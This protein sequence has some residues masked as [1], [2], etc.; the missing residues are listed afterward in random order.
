MPY[1]SA[2]FIRNMPLDTTEVDVLELTRPFGKLLSV[3]F[4]DLDD[5]MRHC[6]VE[7]VFE[8]EEQASSLKRAF[9][10][11]EYAGAVL[12]INAVDAK[13]TEAPVWKMQQ[14]KHWVAAVDPI[15]EEE[16]YN[17]CAV[18]GT[19]IAVR[20]RASTVYIK[21]LR[22]ESAE[23]AIK[24]LQFRSP[25]ALEFATEIA[26][27]E[28]DVVHVAFQ[29]PDSTGQQ[30][31]AVVIDPL[32]DSLDQGA[33]EA[34]LAECRDYEIVVC[35]SAVQGP[36]AQ[37]AIIYTRSKR[38]MVPVYGTLHNQR[39][40]G[41]LL[42][43]FRYQSKEIP[44]R[45][46]HR[47]FEEENRPP[48]KMAIVV[49]PIAPTLSIERISAILVDCGKYDLRITRS[50]AQH[51]QNRL[52]VQPRNLQ[53]KSLCFKALHHRVI[54]GAELVCVRVKQEELPPALKR[55]DDDDTE[56]DG[57]DD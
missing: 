53:A 44:R 36:N 2:A 33:L 9:H 8:T 39:F 11:V 55:S 1:G 38:A 27:E 7:V 45:P 46:R 5:F 18:F 47:P 23:K 41:Q 26:P 6:I 35:K 51:G 20:T 3:V 22:I 19:V 43:L 15:S 25:L 32:P 50:A 57:Y 21:F 30:V 37:R 52:I 49:D 13:T 28:F 14:R 4:R 34:L 16:A 56:E 17:Q 24:T 54:D 29:V 42:S 40:D 12:E 10:Q 48:R 31:M